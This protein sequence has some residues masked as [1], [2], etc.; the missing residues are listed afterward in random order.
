MCVVFISVYLKKV[1]CS[2][3]VRKKELSYEISFFTIRRYIG[4]R[5]Y[6]Q[7]SYSVN[8]ANGSP[9]SENSLSITL[10]GFHACNTVY[11]IH[12]YFMQIYASI[13]C[14]SNQFCRLGCKFLCHHHQL[15]F[16]V[17]QIYLETRR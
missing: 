13:F 7:N 11:I 1:L 2:L 9:V 12:S 3:N 14:Y 15:I 10:Y 5:K 17:F 16:I 8:I 4:I 6:C